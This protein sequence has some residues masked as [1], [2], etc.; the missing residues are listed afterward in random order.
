[1]PRFPVLAIRDFRLLLA[2]RAIAPGAYAFSIV[3]VSFAVLD[4][5]GSTTTLSY[6][7]AAQ[8]APSIVFALLGGVIADRVRPQRVIVAADLMIALGEGGFGALV[9]TGHPTTAQM[10]GLEAVTGM[11][12]ALFWPA[13]Q[14]LLPRLVPDQHL[15]EANAISRLVM[16]L[17]QMGGAAVAGV[18][19]AA[20]G[21]GWALAICGA[22]RLLTVPFML[23]IRVGPPVRAERAALLRDLREGWS[24]FRSRTWLWVIVAQFC[25]I[26][27]A[28]YGAYQVLGPVTAKT[29]LGG[30]A[31][32]GA[33]TAADAFG[34]IAGGVLALRFAPRRPV[35]FVALVAAGIAVAPLSLALLWPLPLLCATAFALGV[36]LEIMTVQ[37]NVIMARAIPPDRLARVSAY[38][39]MGSLLTMP[40]GAL[41]A[42][43]VAAAAGVRPTQ[44]GAA[45]LILLVSALTIAVRDVRAP[46]YPHQ[47]GRP[48]SAR[49]T[50][51]NR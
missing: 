48:A 15:R 22:G 28:W 21:P 25:L 23:A 35:L 17:A 40:V 43:P 14:A 45:V 5:G 30:P 38:D 7:L 29:H 8:I 12:V 18:V 26:L 42:G 11:G 3:G 6:V 46:D 19:V 20:T 10:I 47:R 16:N 2:D 33:I 37:W 41:L 9:L 1:M 4:Q 32:W 24:E 31:A 13:S 49:L 50:A 36:G 51:H 39:A 44:F 27:M 34:L